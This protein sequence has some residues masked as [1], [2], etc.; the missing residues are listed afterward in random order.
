VYYDSYQ[1]EG[2][3][4]PLEKSFLLSIP[5]LLEIRHVHLDN[6]SQIIYYNIIIQ[7]IL[8]DPDYYQGR[9]KVVQ[10]LYQKCMMLVDDWLGELQNTP[11]DMFATF[12]M[13]GMTIKPSIAAVRD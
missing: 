13:V 1:F 8:L 9:G 6:T 4:V 11:A 3:R 5:D 10:Y 12:L 7:G 2:F